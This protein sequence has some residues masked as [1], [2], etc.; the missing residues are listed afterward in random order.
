MRN[1]DFY[2]RQKELIDKALDILKEWFEEYKNDERYKD[3]FYVKGIPP[4]IKQPLQSLR[5]KI[6]FKPIYHKI[7][8]ELGIS[9]HCAKNLVKNYWYSYVINNIDKIKAIKGKYHIKTVV[10][11]LDKII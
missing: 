4:H 7:E 5:N 2:E 1:K 11:S 8:S 6:V 10:N 9:H 3:L